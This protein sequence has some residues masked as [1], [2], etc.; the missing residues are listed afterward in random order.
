M[1]RLNKVCLGCRWPVG[2][3]CGDVGGNIWSNGLFMTSW[4]I[5]S[6]VNKESSLEANSLKQCPKKTLGCLLAGVPFQWPMVTF[7]RGHF[8]I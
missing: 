5:I 1:R 3:R 4:G 7:F 2:K 6:S 8:D